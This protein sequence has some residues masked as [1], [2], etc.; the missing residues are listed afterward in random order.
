MLMMMMMMLM[1]GPAPGVFALSSAG[2]KKKEL[3]LG[4]RKQN[5]HGYQDRSREAKSA[6]R[7][8]Q[9]AALLEIAA[10]G[11]LGRRGRAGFQGVH[12]PD[13][14]TYEVIALALERHA[15]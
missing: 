7:A 12:V 3:H 13:H 15:P 14:F 8:W 10:A 4:S 9:G 5:Q 6:K 11:L 2:E 1:R